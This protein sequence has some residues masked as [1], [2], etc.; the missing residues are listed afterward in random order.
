MPYPIR[1]LKE[2]SLIRLRHLMDYYEYVPRAKCVWI[3]VLL[4]AL[5][6]DAITAGEANCYWEL[7]G[8]LN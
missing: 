3:V 1:G 2:S 6:F 7:H 4:E 8:R 5:E